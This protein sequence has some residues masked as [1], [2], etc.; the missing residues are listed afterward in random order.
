MDIQLRR[1]LLDYCVLAVLK[2]GDSYGYMIIKKMASILEIS[3]STLYPILKRLETNSYVSSYSVEHN[4]RL[5]KYY[6]ITTKGIQK[7]ISFNDEWSEIEKVY[8]YIKGANELWHKMNL[9]LH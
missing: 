5:R 2:E 9:F 8:N 1:G 4:G 7:L 6:K 3:E